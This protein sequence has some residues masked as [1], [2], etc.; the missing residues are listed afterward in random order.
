MV[1]T[2]DVEKEGQIAHTAYGFECDYC[3]IKVWNKDTSR[4]AFH[5]LGDVGLRDAGSGFTGIEVYLRVL[6]NVAD[7]AKIEM[8]AKTANNAR[9]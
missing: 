1:I 6:P 7:C 3:K 8:A 5:L 4:P 2:K 9:K